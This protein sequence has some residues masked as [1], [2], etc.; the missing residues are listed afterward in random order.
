MPTILLSGYYGFNNIGDEAVLGGILA[1]LRT[2]LPDATP[3]VLSADPATTRALHDV[4]AIPRMRLST[5]R[6]ALRKT[7]LFVSGGG[8]L[9]Q[10]VTSFR[11]PLYYLGLLWLAQRAGVPTAVIAQGMGPL[12]HPLNRRFA[13]RILD[14]TRAITVRDDASANFLAELGVSE[15]PCT[16]T[17]DPSFLLE[18]A[19]SERLES[20]WDAHIPANRPIVGV[21]L[22]RWPLANPAERYTAIADAVAALA[23]ATG[24][25]LLFLPMQYNT[26]LSIA[27]EIAGWTPAENVV[28]NLALS[29]REMLEVVGRCQFILAMRLHTL[30]FAVQRG[31]PALGLAY[32]PKVLDFS[33]ASGLPLPPRWE[34]LSAETLTPELQQLWTQRHTYRT[35]LQEQAIR[36]TACARKN[37]TCISK[38]LS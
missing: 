6:A 31:T 38:L 34:S 17:A 13:R 16:V 3:I 27:E 23:E 21:A 22:R 36:L 11:S 20:W 14:R 9:L 25:L 26:D 30:I 19:T 24:A 28:L 18:P 12:G 15:V 5:I 8:S 10:D 32:D 33:I 37:I 35:E 1:G 4:S 7:D 2:E 29:P